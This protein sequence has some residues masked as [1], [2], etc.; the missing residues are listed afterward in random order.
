MFEDF[1]KR[2]G[3]L[4]GLPEVVLTPRQNTVNREMAIEEWSYGPEAPLLSK[5]ANKPF[6]AGL[7][8]AWGID[9]AEARHRMCGNCEYWKGCP[10]TQAMLEAI[11]V[12]SYDEAGGAARGYCEAHEFACAASR[13]CKS[14]EEFE[15]E[16]GYD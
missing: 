12:T 10:D 14:W 6:Y 16:E 4:G 2:L 13:V 5:A 7:A 11:P 3:E 8:R 1:A 15:R 9:E